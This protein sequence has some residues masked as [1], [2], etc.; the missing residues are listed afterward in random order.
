MNNLTKE[1]LEL[2]SK[3]MDALIKQ[4]EKDLEMEIQVRDRKPSDPE[5]AELLDIMRNKSDFMDYANKR[6]EEKTKKV[7][8]IKESVIMIKAK[9]LELSKEIEI[10]N[11]TQK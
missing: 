3:S 9:I 10:Y 2:L 11:L 1:D 8:D 7:D 5:L 4:E 6:I